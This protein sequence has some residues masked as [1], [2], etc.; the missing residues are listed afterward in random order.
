MAVTNFSPLLGLALPTT[1]DLS[2]TWGVTVNDA[3]TSLID[4]AVAGTTT[5]SADADV[6]LSTTNGA[7]NQARNAVILWTAS[8]GATTRNITAPAQSKAY[9]VI[10]AGTGSVVIR[11]SG[12]TTGVTVTSGTKAL[13][14]W[15]GSDFVKIASSLVNLTSDVTGTLP[16]V[17][18]GTGTTSTTFVNLATNVTGNLP[19]TNLNSGTSASAT[20]FWRGDGTWGTPPGT[21]GLGTVTSVS[22]ASSNGFAG[23]VANATTTPA[24]TLTTSITGILKGN[25]TAISAAVAGTDYVTPT[26]TET[27]TNKTLTAPTIASANLTTALTLSG[28]AGTN[29]QVITSAGSGLPSWTTI[30]SGALTLLSTVT[31][32][33]SATVDIETTFSSTYDTYML[34]VNGLKPSNTGQTPICRLK[35]G[36]SYITSSTYRYWFFNPLTDAAT[37]SQ[38][39]NNAGAEIYLASAISNDASTPGASF[40]INI[41]NPTPTGSTKTIYWKGAVGVYDN[42]SAFQNTDGFAGNSTAGALTGVRIYFP[43]GTVLSGVF[44][45]YGLAN[46]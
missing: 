3:I 16:I 43:A 34:V 11:G 15:N 36:G 13:V 9:V 29:G 12:P 30:N 38:S 18:G 27:L 23:T 41:H 19:T 6:T 33:S 24:I 17:N 40:V 21:G 4:S 31:A 2:G 7:A 10:N 39:N 8:N 35:I 37:V 20:T 1:G 44:R 42:S 26:G 32:S 46:S 22:V 28:A 45:L 25:A 5:L 14:A